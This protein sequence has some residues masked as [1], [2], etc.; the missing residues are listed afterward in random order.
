MYIS[1]IFVSSKKK[2][3]S[4]QNKQN[5]ENAR[6]LSVSRST[7]LRAAASCVAARGTSM[8]AIE[9]IF[10]LIEIEIEA[11]DP[12]T[13]LHTLWLSNFLLQLTN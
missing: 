6:D 3:I 13:K 4:K 8:F 1:A 11:K 5:E 12:H 9:D 2:I 10:L 7:A